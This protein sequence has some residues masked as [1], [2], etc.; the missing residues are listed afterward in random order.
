MQAKFTE[1][2]VQNVPDESGIFCLFHERDLVYIGRTA[3]R[4]G[5][6]SEL[7]RA[8]KIAMAAD[9]LATHFTYELTAAPKTRATEELREYYGT[10]GRLPL[11]NQPH[12]TSLERSA[13]LRR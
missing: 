13:E 4:I 5:L 9:M 10:W 1:A 6:R 3:P 8:L 12:A 2:D 11:Y 7:L